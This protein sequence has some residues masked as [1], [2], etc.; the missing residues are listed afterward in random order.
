MT[1][2][3]MGTAGDSGL[4]RLRHNTARPDIVGADQPQPIDPLGVGEVGRVGD[5]AVV[6][7]VSCGS[8][9]GSTRTRR[10]GGEVTARSSSS[11]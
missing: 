11:R 1:R 9:L 4:W 7:D 3:Q 10:E 5:V 6:H 8:Q 2:P